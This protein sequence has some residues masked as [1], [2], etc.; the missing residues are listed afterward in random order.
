MLRD[1]S[2]LEVHAASNVV[3]VFDEMFRCKQ[4]GGTPAH[5]D[6]IQLTRIAVP[7]SLAHG[8]I[9]YMENKVEKSERILNCMPWCNALGNA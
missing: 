4:L 7:E 2:K 3:S 1:V 8:F 5:A 6:I 9:K